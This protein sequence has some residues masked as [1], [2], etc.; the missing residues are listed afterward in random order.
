MSEHQGGESI[1]FAESYRETLHQAFETYLQ[2]HSEGL[3]SPY[4][5]SVGCGFAY[6]TPVVVNMFP[7]AH[8]EGIDIKPELVFGAKQ[9]NKDIKGDVS[10][11]IADAT[12]DEAYKNDKWDVIIL[13]HPQ[14][15]GSI[16]TN[17]TTTDTWQTIVE[18][19]IDHL[20]KGGLFFSTVSSPLEEEL[21]LQALPV[22]KTEVLEHA[23]NK[24]TNDKATYDDK[25]IIIAR[26]I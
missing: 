14:M 23:V 26:K 6:E 12:K 8:Y 19:S 18:K 9:T 21:L 5:L 20:K 10:F 1:N 3:V 15:Q 4:V 13:R 25:V 22:S 11:R 2:P 17:E 7:K 16:L 24:F